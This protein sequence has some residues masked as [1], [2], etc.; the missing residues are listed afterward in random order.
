[1]ERDTHGHSPLVVRAKDLLT[2]G[3][4]LEVPADLVVLATGVVPHDISELISMYRCAVGYD[5]FLL[6]VHPKLRPVELA[7]SGVF[8]ADYC[9]GPMDVT[10]ACAAAS[11]AAS[12][13][14]AE[15]KAWL[16]E[17][18]DVRKRLRGALA[19]GPRT[20]PEAA[21]DAGLEPALALWHLMAMRRYGEV[22]KAGERDRY[23]STR[24][25]RAEAMP[26]GT[27]YRVND[28]LGEELARFGGPTL[29]RCFNCGNCTAVCG[30]SD[31]EH[32]FPRR[33]IRHLQLGLE[34]R[35]L[36]STDPLATRRSSPWSSSS[37]R[38]SRS[39]GA[40]PPAGTGRRSSATTAPRCCSPPRCGSPA[41]AGGSGT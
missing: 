40:A 21:T 37:S 17:Q 16:K 32:A 41:T 25:R 18:Q 11:A 15:M 38:S 5:S 7:V 20:V 28:G 24:S 34:K 14:A 13:A 2:G 33:V 6:E 19:R 31:G 22:A 26:T 3:L 23:V 39:R 35:L 29:D 10:E 27:A 12:K 8:L 36:E 30:L 4:E 1:M 9:Q